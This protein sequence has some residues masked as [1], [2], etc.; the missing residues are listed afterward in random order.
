MGSLLS[1]DLYPSPAIRLQA[2]TTIH[3]TNEAVVVPM[4][5]LL[6]SG[7]R[8]DSVGVLKRKVPTYGY[9]LNIEEQSG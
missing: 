6:H 5:A 8:V 9:K 3:D 2:L 4:T 7:L 1:L